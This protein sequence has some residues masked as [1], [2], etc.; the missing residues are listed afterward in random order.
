MDD[1]KMNSGGWGGIEKTSATR[2]NTSFSLTVLVLGHT[3]GY[4]RPFRAKQTRNCE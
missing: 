3:F 1:Y 4:T 2:A